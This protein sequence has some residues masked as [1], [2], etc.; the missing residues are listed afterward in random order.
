MKSQQYALSAAVLAAALAGASVP[1]SAAYVSTFDASGSATITGF[2][3]GNSK[4]FSVDLFDMA[5]TMHL[6]KPFGNWI[7]SVVVSGNLAADFNQNGSLG[8]PTLLNVPIPSM[9]L[10]GG[11][12]AMSGLNLPVYNFGFAPGVPGSHDGPSAPIAFDID[13]DGVMPPSTLAFINALFGTSFVN[14]N[15][16]GRLS[17]AGTVYS[18][19]ILMNVTESNLS[20]AGFGS[21]LAAADNVYG[22]ATPDS[23]TIDFDTALTFRVVPEP[24]SLALMG[25]GLMGL[26]LA[27]RRK[28]A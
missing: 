8:G 2:A 11:F 14:P 7:E 15:G 6:E 25:L 24:A 4:T 13:Y 3:D 17:V 19:G 1:A 22:P 16:A 18:D 12:A 23:I 28:A 21:L 10:F 20:W 5:G 9:N 26:G 27:R